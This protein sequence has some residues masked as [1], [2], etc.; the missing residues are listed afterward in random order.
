M[1]ETFHAALSL[2]CMHGLGQR[3]VCRT[4]STTLLAWTSSFAQVHAGS[5]VTSATSRRCFTLNISKLTAESV[6]V[7][8][9][10]CSA[11][12]GLLSFL[13]RVL[14]FPGTRCSIPQGH[15]RRRNHAK[16][17]WA[18]TWR[19][20]CQCVLQWPCTAITCPQPCYTVSRRAVSC[21]LSRSCTSLQAWLGSVAAA[22]VI[23]AAASA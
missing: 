12:A 15:T 18:T 7:L 9:V 19:K 3:P 4:C 20:E 2:I 6:A 14:M 16:L 21:Q 23:P 5:R 17:Q 8:Q 13:I 1:I 11:T 10:A 22:L